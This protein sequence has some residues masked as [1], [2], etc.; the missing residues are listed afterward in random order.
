VADTASPRIVRLAS[1]SETVRFSLRSAPLRPVRAAAVWQYHTHGVLA[2]ERSRQTSTSSEIDA[3]GFLRG[4]DGHRCV[5]TNTTVVVRAV[6]GATLSILLPTCVKLSERHHDRDPEPLFPGEIEYLEKAV[7]KRRLEFVTARRCARDA[8]GGI[9]VTRPP[10]VPGVAGSPPWPTGIVGS[11]TH[12]AGYRGAAVAWDSDV[13]G[14]GIDAEPH[15]GLPVDVLDVVAT[16]LEVERISRLASSRPDIAWDRLLF[17]AKESVYKVWFPL[18]RTWLGF[19]EA[20]V[21]LEESG[22]F[23]ATLARELALPGGV[24]TRELRGR[25]ASDER[26]VV[27]AVTILAASPPHV[28]GATP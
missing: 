26:H 19:E 6:T 3:W 10:M 8:L 23:R 24:S 22:R 27:T 7:E 2:A 18:S 1:S 11:I 20:D 21:T 14:L 13:W 25:W 17:S 4:R 5:S 28:G 9:G 15:E 12:C 16:D